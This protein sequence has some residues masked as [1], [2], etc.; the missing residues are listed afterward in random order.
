MIMKLN[1]GIVDFGA[2]NLFSIQ[3]SIQ[4]FDLN[5]MIVNSP[6]DLKEIDCLIIPGVGSFA[7]AIR[8]LTSKGLIEPIIEF[9]LTKSILG[10]CLG[11]QIFASIGFEGSATNGLNLLNGEVK[12]LNV[13]LP[14]PHV[15]WNSV[16]ILNHSKLFNGIESDT[17]FYFTHSY[18]MELNDIGNVVGVTNYDIQFVSAVVKHNIVGVQFHPE[19][20]G[21]NGLKL[22]ENYFKYYAKN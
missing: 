19:K 13:N 14:V 11:F 17:D 9:S 6:N 12:K 10:I 20:S 7:S 18:Y 21:S 5:V 8:E 22:L 3:N 2:G 16:S 1:V 15:G 4:K